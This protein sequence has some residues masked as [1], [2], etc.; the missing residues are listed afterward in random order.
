MKSKRSTIIFLLA[1]M[2]NLSFAQNVKKLKVEASTKADQIENK[3][4]EWRH[5]IHEN[6]E[7]SNREFETG[8]YIAEHL[9]SLGIEVSVAAAWRT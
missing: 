7:L 8:K 1:M 3:V 9:R 4:I 6:P 2:S 5:H